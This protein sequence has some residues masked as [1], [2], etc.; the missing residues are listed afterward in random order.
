MRYKF[1]SLM[2]G[3]ILFAGGDNEL[4][5]EAK[6]N[7]KS[8]KFPPI[9]KDEI[10]KAQLELGEKLFYDPRFSTDGTIS[11]SKCHIAGL[12][13]TD[14]MNQSTGANGM[15]SKR[16][17]QTV[18]NSSNQI[19]QHWIG[20]R[21]DLNDQV[22]QSFVSHIA[23]GN[24][25]YEDTIL[26]LKSI[27]GYNKLFAKAYPKDKEPI[28]VENAVN[29]IVEY[30]KILVNPSNFDKF[31]DGNLKAISENAKVGLKTFM[32]KGCVT[33][34]NGDSI[35]G[36]SYQKFGIHQDYWKLTKSERIDYG[37]STFTR[38]DEDRYSFKVSG[39]RNVEMTKPYFHDGS[40]KTL[41][42]AIDIMAKAQL[43][44]TLTKQEIDN[45]EEFLNSLTGYIPQ[46]LRTYP[47]LPK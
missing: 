35:G 2:I 20:N 34:H 17:T 28:N 14:G 45:I 37:R 11:C 29:S 46:N 38:K 10:S 39:L 44:I 12:Y 21:L 24:K 15:K 36:N 8:I 33:C 18:L 22:K 26:K 5:L 32:D 43:N 25:T 13:F 19:A 47:I 42:E 7:F 3:S 1:L 40:V 27:N 30:E 9:P 31:L 41:K 4:L 23:F 6:K 16:N